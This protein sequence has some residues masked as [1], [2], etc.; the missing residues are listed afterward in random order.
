MLLNKKRCQKIRRLLSQIDPCPENSLATRIYNFF[1]AK[2]IAELPD[3][4]KHE[5]KII[6]W[7]NE[8]MRILNFLMKIVFSILNKLKNCWKREKNS[9]SYIFWLIFSAD[10]EKT[11]HAKTP[12]FRCYGKK[13]F[14]LW[15]LGNRS[16]VHNANFSKTKLNIQEDLGKFAADNS[17]PVRRNIKITFFTKSV[18]LR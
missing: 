12:Y 5:K 10:F 15:Y 8:K 16:A 4:K 14:G 13:I 1:F 2:K 3:P 11:E 6:T 7:K 9:S 18:I 17:H